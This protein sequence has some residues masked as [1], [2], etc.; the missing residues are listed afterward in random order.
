MSDFQKSFVKARLAT[1]PP[2]M[3]GEDD[4]AV[5]AS[6]PSSADTVTPSPTRQLFARPSRGYI[7]TSLQEQSVGLTSTRAK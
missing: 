4:D 7:S 3:D 6:S 2:V 5:D 1:L